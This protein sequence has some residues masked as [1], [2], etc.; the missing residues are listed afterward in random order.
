MWKGP[1]GSSMS[2]LKQLWLENRGEWQE[3][4]YAWMEVHVWDFDLYLKSKRKPLTDIK[5]GEGIW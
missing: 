3:A 5:Q 1:M 4:N 2:L